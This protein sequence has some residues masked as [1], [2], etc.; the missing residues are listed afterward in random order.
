MIPASRSVAQNTGVSLSC[1]S[2]HP[3]HS[4]RHDEVLALF[5]G[6]HDGN[7]KAP[8][9]VAYNGEQV[10]P[11]SR[12]SSQRMRIRPGVVG[13]RFSRT[14][15]ALRTR[16]AAAACSWRPGRIQLCR[17]ANWSAR[18]GRRGRCR[19]RPCR[20]HQ[21]RESPSA[22]SSARCS[23]CRCRPGCRPKFRHD[24]IFP[25]R[26]RPAFGASS[27]AVARV[28][29]ASVGRRGQASRALLLPSFQ[30]GK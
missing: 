12:T 27:S 26:R 30:T 18:P 2:P 14:A 13:R 11:V 25:G 1:I 21:C 8:Y 10:R 19:L 9:G 4:F 3:P 5:V 24:E 16:P 17:A 29:A 15:A 20:R 6:I 22:W 23:A 28:G 7:E